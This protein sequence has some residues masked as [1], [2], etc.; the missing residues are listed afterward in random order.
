MAIM[1]I[2]IFS[3]SLT[4]ETSLKGGLY[5]KANR[6]LTRYEATDKMVSLFSER[7][8]A[9]LSESL[10]NTWV[11]FKNLGVLAGCSFSSLS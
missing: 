8:R 10:Y 11:V 3:Y 5:T 2:I 7:E 4:F 9:A 6:Y 1:C